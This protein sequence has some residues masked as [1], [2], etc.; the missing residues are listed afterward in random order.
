MLARDKSLAKILLSSHRIA[1]P[2]HAVFRIGRRIKRPSRLGFPLIV[3]SLTKEGS[4]GIAQASIVSNDDE[5]A[6]RVR[7]VHERQKTHAI[8][9]QYIDGREIYAGVVG[10]E[11]LQVFPLWELHFS[12]LPED[13]PRIATERVKW[14]PAYQKKVGV[15][16]RAAKD[17][18]DGLDVAIPRLVKRVYRALYLNGYARIDLRLDES[19]KVFVLEANP[20]PQLAYGEDFAESAE[21]AGI[22]YPALLHRIVTLG[23][24]WSSERAA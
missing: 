2:E 8:A 14:D 13:A 20:N 9:E 21:H 12:R 3:K 19:G 1:V 11:R 17:L 16:T 4:V 7:M 24:S 23:L 10:N 15:R 22:D 18:P 6:E 5:L